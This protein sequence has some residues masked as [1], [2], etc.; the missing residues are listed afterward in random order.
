MNF[1]WQ[2]QEKKENKSSKND[3]I[4]K[5]KDIL[6]HVNESNTIDMNDLLLFSPFKNES[7]SNNGKKHLLYIDK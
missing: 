4:N 5:N 7:F 6:D 3:I 1:N 2:R